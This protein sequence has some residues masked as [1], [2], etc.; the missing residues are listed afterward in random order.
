MKQK[1]FYLLVAITSYFAGILTYLGYLSF[2]YDEKIGSE[3]S[4]FLVWTIPPYLFIILP[5][6][7]LIFRWRR[8]PLWLRAVMLFGLSIIAA[9]SVPFLIGFGVW[10]IRD[11]FSPELR[12]FIMFFASSALLFTIGSIVAIKERGYFIFLLASLA[13]ISLAINLLV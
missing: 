8:T 13:I 9:A 5:Y 7:T 2:I 12:L 4:K 11:L 6:Y 3:W 1:L 10:R